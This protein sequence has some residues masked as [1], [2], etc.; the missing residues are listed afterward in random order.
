[1]K[2]FSYFVFLF[3]FIMHHVFVCACIYVHIYVHLFVCIHIYI[4]VYMRMRDCIRWSISFSRSS[5]DTILF[6]TA[7][8]NFILF[9]FIFFQHFFHFFYV[10]YLTFFCFILFLLILSNFIWYNFDY[11]TLG[12]KKTIQRRIRNPIERHTTQRFTTPHNHVRT[13]QYLFLFLNNA[14]LL[15]SIQ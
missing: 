15:H 5:I 9:I 2:I 13:V 7:L 6:P 10:I 14:T 8:F 3:Y 12:K 4:Y 11:A 1:M